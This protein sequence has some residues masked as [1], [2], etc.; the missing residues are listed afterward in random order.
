[1]FNDDRLKKYI[2]AVEQEQEVLYPDLLSF[3][4]V[5][6]SPAKKTF[7]HIQIHEGYKQTI[8]RYI[9]N[10]NTL[11]K[12]ELLCILSL[13]S[14]EDLKEIEEV[15]GDGFY[16]VS[17]PDIIV[18]LDHEHVG[19][20]I[21]SVPIPEVIL[22]LV[23]QIT[24]I[25][26]VHVLLEEVIREYLITSLPDP[27]V[28][29]SG[30]ELPLP[31]YPI[32]S[33]PLPIIDLEGIVPLA[34][35]IIG[36]PEPIVMLDS[37]YPTHEIISIPEPIVILGETVSTDNKYFYGV[38]EIDPHA[39][40]TRPTEANFTNLIVGFSNII[41]DDLRISFPQATGFYIF[42]IPASAPIRRSW[43]VSER[44][45]GPIGGAWDDPFSNLW[46]DP[47]QQV[48]Q[49]VLYNVYISSYPTTFSADVYVKQ[50][51]FV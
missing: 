42:A 12:E 2:Q 29:L 25:P 27:I 31:E 35:E 39:P 33:L 26:Q 48:Y 37:L 11:T 28:E 32:T 43:F 36:L 6:L 8:K 23:R 9:E 30:V 17:V 21:V 20:Q 44:N 7:K 4:K 40:Y 13:Y 19:Y 49:D 45:Q 16:I 1:M 34:P 10:R 47:I 3:Y 22:P 46:P 18:M 24:S 15:I 41:P 51:P 38:F 50:A 14:I 5:N